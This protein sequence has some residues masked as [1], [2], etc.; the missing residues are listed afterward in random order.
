VTTATVEEGAVDAQPDDT[1]LREACSYARAARHAERTGNGGG[2]CHLVAEAIEQRFG[3]PK[4][5]GAYTAPNGDVICEAHCWN[6]IPGIGIFDATADQFGEGHDIRFVVSTDAEARRYRPEWYEDWNPVSE[7]SCP[8]NLGCSRWTGEL[9]GH[10]ANRLRQERGDT[11]WVTDSVAFARYRE[12][13]ARYR[14]PTNNLEEPMHNDTQAAG[15][16]AEGEYQTWLWDDVTESGFIIRPEDS[17]ANLFKSEQWCDGDI[18]N[19][20]YGTYDEAVQW[21]ERERAGHEA[22]VARIE[23]P[24]QPV[25]TGPRQ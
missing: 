7:P 19:V 6:E 10:Q 4:R 22:L 9:D 18:V 23:A 13:D 24:V 3:W 14:E 15:R 2:Q 25:A 17:D 8:V 12:N 16:P 21:T 11:W 1:L 20:H 5:S